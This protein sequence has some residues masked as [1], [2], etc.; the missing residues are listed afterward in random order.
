MLIIALAGGG[1]GH[2]QQ[3]GC[4]FN[5]VINNVELACYNGEKDTV[6]LRLGEGNDQQNQKAN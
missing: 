1:R 5:K 3:W 6:S 4:D 2:K